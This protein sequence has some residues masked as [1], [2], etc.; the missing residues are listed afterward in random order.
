M[1]LHELKTWPLYFAAVANGSKPFEVRKDDRGFAV[2][3]VLWLREWD[4]A[5]QE[6]TGEECSAVVTYVLRDY[7]PAIGAGYAV[8]G[9]EGVPPPKERW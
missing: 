5:T 8:L 6:Y 9:V 2:G 7:P 4:P 1:T 3:D